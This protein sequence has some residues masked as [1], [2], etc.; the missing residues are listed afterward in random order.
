MPLNP[1][2]IIK[3]IFFNDSEKKEVDLQ[4]LLHGP[5]FEQIR[6]N[7]VYFREVHVDAESGTICWD[8][9]ADNDAD[10]LYGSFALLGEKLKISFW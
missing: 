2:M 4:P 3:L 7:T 1:W 9:G 8:N 10:V 5:I 6:Q